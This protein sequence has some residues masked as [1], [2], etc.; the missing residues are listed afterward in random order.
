MLLPALPHSLNSTFSRF[1]FTLLLRRVKLL[2]SLINALDFWKNS[3]NPPVVVAPQQTASLGE[4]LNQNYP[5]GGLPR[6]LALTNRTD[7]MI[8]VVLRY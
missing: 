6:F 8:A 4:P 1:S 7:K 2:L 5:A 3:K